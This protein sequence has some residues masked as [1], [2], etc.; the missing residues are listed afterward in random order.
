VTDKKATILSKCDQSAQ[1]SVQGPGQIFMRRISTDFEKG[2]SGDWKVPSVDMQDKFALPEEAK[3][4]AKILPLI[5]RRMVRLIIGTISFP[6]VVEMLRSVYVEEAQK[7][8]VRDGTNPTKSALAL[9]SGIDTRVVSNVIKDD[10]S[11]DI[12]PQKLIPE[13]ALLDTWLKDPFF[14]D[15]T[16]QK[17]ALLP[18]EGRGKTFHGLVLRSIGRNITVKTVLDKLL[19]SGNVG[20]VPGNID[21]VEMLS[22]FYSPI[23]S[24]VANLT[25]IAFLE[26]SRILSTVSH[27]IDTEQDK[28]VPQQGRWTYRLNQKKYSEFRQRARQLLEK[29]IKEGE[30]LLEEFEEPTKQ[31]GQLTVGIGWYQWGD[32]EPEKEVE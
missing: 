18:I 2:F 11:L 28:R 32:H 20:V 10:F 17:P 29:Q 26:A 5:L 21:R 8:L 19:A 23:S 30:S 4:I 14:Q 22:L 12:E 25:D 7:K 1:T 16:S 27:N 13:A 24:D 31:P 9:V 3:A 15:P 6:A